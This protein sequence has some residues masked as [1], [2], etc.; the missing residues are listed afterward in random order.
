MAVALML[1][2]N[3]FRWSVREADVL[4]F[5]DGH[6][7]SPSATPT[8]VSF[9]ETGGAVRSLCDPAAK[10]NDYPAHLGFRWTVLVSTMSPHRCGPRVAPRRCGAR[11]IPLPASRGELKKT[12]AAFSCASLIM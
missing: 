11:F 2:F 6:R 1:A 4:A 7:N 3:S 9:A 8:Q 12:Y 10:A 5:A